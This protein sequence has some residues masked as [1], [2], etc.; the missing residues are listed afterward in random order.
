MLM[1][2]RFIR[3]SS[4]LLILFAVT[5]S[6]AS[7]SGSLLLRLVPESDKVTVPPE[8][9]VTLKNI[10]TPGMNPGTEHTLK[11]KDLTALLEDIVP[12][13]YNVSVKG[14]DVSEFSG[15]AII[16][17]GRQAEF[18]VQMERV[19]ILPGKIL[20][21]DSRPVVNAQVMARKDVK[22]SDIDRF[23]FF[24]GSKCV[25]TDTNGAFQLEGLVEGPYKIRISHPDMITQ[26]ESV[27]IVDGENKPRTFMMRSGLQ[28][29]GK[30]IESD[31]SPASGLVI[32]VSGPLDAGR[33]RDVNR[34]ANIDDK[35]FFKQSGL[36]MGK[37]NLTVQNAASK[38]QEQIVRDVFAGTTDL[39]IQ[40][41][42]KCLV[43]GTVK[44][45]EG[46]PVKDA[47][48]SLRRITLGSRTTADQGGKTVA[49]TDAEGKFSLYLKYGH[50]Y[51]IKAVCHPL[52][53]GIATLMLPEK[54][55]KNVWPVSIVLER[56]ETIKGTVISAKDA[57]PLK[58]ISVRVSPS[59]GLGFMI[60]NEPDEVI[61][62]TGDDG[63]F[64]IEG[65]RPGMSKLII[66]PADN[67]RWIL[68]TQQV[69]IKKGPQPDI[70][71]V[72]KEPGSVKGTVSM[73]S[74]EG[75]KPAVS[76][77]NPANPQQNF[78]ADVDDKGNFT[79]DNV[80]PG[81]YMVT[82]MSSIAPEAAQGK[83]GMGPR[84]APLTTRVTVKSGQTATV[85]I[86]KNT[87]QTEVG[88]FPLKG[89]VLKQ[90]NPFGPG[91]IDFAPTQPSIS[92]GK[93][94]L[95]FRV[96]K[97]SKLDATGAF[98]IDKMEAGEFVYVVRSAMTDKPAQQPL[99]IPQSYSGVVNVENNNRE[100][101]INIDGSTL[102]GFVRD[103]QGF[104]VKGVNVIVSPEISDGIMKQ[105]LTKHSQT[106]A[107]GKY[108]L[109]CI[110]PGTYSV[111]VRNMDGSA[112]ASENN[113]KLSRKLHNL[114]LPL[115]D[116]YKIYG[117][118]SF[119]DNTDEMRGVATV[120]VS[121]KDDSIPGYGTVDENGG[122]VITP[123]L[124]AGEYYVFNF[125][126]GYAISENKIN[127]EKDTAVN[128]TL[129]PGGAIS[130]VLK[131]SSP[132]NI[133]ERTVHVKAGDGREIL[134]CRKPSQWTRSGG[135]WSR[136]LIAPTD[137]NGNTVIS[138]LKED[139][140]TISIDGSDKTA[141][142]KVVPLKETIVEIN[143]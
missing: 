71:I 28:I 1:Y 63:K 134:R 141:T 106:G 17:K 64:S 101:T 90:G 7:E 18:Q 31:G 55:D 135:P 26:T 44:D 54:A 123:N 3:I 30:V 21:K 16:E 58:G 27:N 99:P 25:S 42:E 122:Y 87:E 45:P 130:V 38:E 41:R 115:K 100:L 66:T 83:T 4:A 143:I 108:S 81:E 24:T 49:V 57:S 125:K 111:N 77:H 69:L 35:G 117:R 97:N 53:P 96:G 43:Q 6:Y 127:L 36:T 72:I 137:E 60:K 68:E 129:V 121:C 136:L 102:E 75:A 82:A 12:A 112:S 78:T 132:E 94:M 140:Y 34:I 47:G 19:F 107:D 62:P 120:A 22:I 5:G 50:K 76:M 2:R 32:A 48:I 51:E 91:T 86:K 56:G 20:D 9:T 39:V 23:T 110:P 103:K 119:P 73:E 131:S 37:Y 67:P 118:V 46:K 33:A 139:T 14:K 105:R 89:A 128:G 29:S 79:I 10:M 98:T 88:T 138:G 84:S 61:A 15:K 93:E 13:T 133:A 126:D 52:L 124:P 92:P 70:T 65:L 8:I 113:L 116:N 142:C 40:L 114:D 109:D 74:F 80:P 11:V 95:L 85:E 104:P 59:A